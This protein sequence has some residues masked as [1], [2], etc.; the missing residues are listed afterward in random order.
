MITLFITAQIIFTLNAGV[1]PICKDSGYPAL[2][3]CYDGKNKIYISEVTSRP[4]DYILYHEIGHS[5]L[6]KDY[7]KGKLKTFSDVETMAWEFSDYVYDYK[8]NRNTK[9]PK[10]HV[11]I[12]QR[13]CPDKCLKEI[14]GIP[15]VEAEQPLM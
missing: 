14:I 4:K 15:M 12:F 1:M 8:Y 6:N 7:F 13:K 10:K 9:I 5:L 2:D 3:G 11:K